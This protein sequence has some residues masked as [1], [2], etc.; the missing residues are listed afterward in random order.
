[1]LLTLQTYAEQ[2]AKGV[3][4]AVLLDGAELTACIEADSE[5]GYVI[6]LVHEKKPSGALIFKLDEKGERL[7]ERKEGSV[8]IRLTHVLGAVSYA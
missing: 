5:A 4:C 8:Q 2:R 1:M 6:C 7:T 3:E